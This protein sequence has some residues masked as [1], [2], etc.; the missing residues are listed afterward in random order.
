MND[1]FLLLLVLALVL[2]AGM[3]WE[4]YSCDSR[5]SQMG[6]ETSW[7]PSTGCLIKVKGSWIDIDHYRVMQ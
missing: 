6:L 7:Y 1:Y 5:G 3:G 4:S 2:F